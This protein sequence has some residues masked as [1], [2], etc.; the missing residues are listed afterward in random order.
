[1]KS[2]H[3]EGNKIVCGYSVNLLFI[4]GEQSEPRI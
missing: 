4:C 1:M 3:R 2:L